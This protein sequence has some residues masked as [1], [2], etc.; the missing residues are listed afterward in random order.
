M[1]SL[2]R[3]GRRNIKDIDVVT[4]IKTTRQ[5]FEREKTCGHGRHVVGRSPYELRSGK[6]TRRL[7]ACMFRFIG[8]CM[9]ACGCKWSHVLAYRACLVR[10]AE[11]GGAA[12][13]LE[14]HHI[15]EKSYLSDQR[16][17]MTARNAEGTSPRS[18]QNPGAFQWI[19]NRLHRSSCAQDAE[20]S[21]RP[22]FAGVGIAC[23][24]TDPGCACVFEK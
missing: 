24:R 10:V 7:H 21:P 13:E 2:E 22:P 3:S 4:K 12:N 16:I 15:K 19:R 5:H 14:Y 18:Y 1:A 11:Y 17:R 23:I 8:R 9:H 6:G 20:P